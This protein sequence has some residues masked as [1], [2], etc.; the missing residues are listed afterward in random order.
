MVEDDSRPFAQ[1]TLFILCSFLG[2]LT[3]IGRK[4]G[5]LG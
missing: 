3:D 1:T 5:R 4:V 2:E